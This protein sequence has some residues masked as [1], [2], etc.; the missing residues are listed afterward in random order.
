MNQMNLYSYSEN[1][2]HP[3]ILKLWRV[4]NLLLFGWCGNSLRQLL[5]RIFGA[6]IGS[7]CLICRG[8]VVYAPWNLEM[9][10]MVCIGPHC[11][12]YNKAKIIIGSGVVVS[13]D[14]YLCTASHD[15]ASRKMALVT[16]AIKVQ[17]NVWI[18]ARASILPGVTI[19]EGVVVGACA[20]VAKDVPPWSVV[21]GNPASVV[22][23]RVLA[24]D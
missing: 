8:V 17:D 10:E 11:E 1:K 20:V 23:S 7:G 15:V 16:K 2:D 18:A 9:G 12:I 22:K 19:G 6:K 5:L 4:F 13:Q 21:V 24:D 14:A 3:I